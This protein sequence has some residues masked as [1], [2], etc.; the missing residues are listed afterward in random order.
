MER[1]I[2]IGENKVSY[3]E[4]GKGLPIIILH[5]WDESLD[6]Y[7]KFQE[8]LATRG[9]RVFIPY[10]PGLSERKNPLEKVWSS[11]DYA[12]WLLG[13]AKELKLKKFFLFGHSFGSVI[14]TT[15]TALYPQEL[16]GLIL[17]GPPKSGK[18]F[19]P[20]RLLAFSGILLKFLNMIKKILPEKSRAWIEKQYGIYKRSSG[21][22]FKT[23]G[24][25]FSKNTDL[26]LNQ[27]RISTLIV[28]GEKD[29]SLVTCSARKIN[30]KIISSAL[31][32]FKNQSHHLQDACPG[33]LADEIEKFIKNIQ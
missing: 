6:L 12:V 21:N 16:L 26:Y 7:L 1:E 20:I 30:K 19:C 11:E 25:V 32:V 10:L 15:F 9:Y 27:I 33:E 5:G 31:R 23:L 8:I 24:V 28:C 2:L 13:L 3:I 22:M 18:E 14:A 4:K 29:S 17:S